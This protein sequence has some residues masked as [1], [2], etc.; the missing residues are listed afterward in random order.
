MC[1]EIQ[2][3]KIQYNFSPFKLKALN[4]NVEQIIKTSISKMSEFRGNISLHNS[5]S[6]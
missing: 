5:T 3:L 2:G 4:R 1:R 6:E